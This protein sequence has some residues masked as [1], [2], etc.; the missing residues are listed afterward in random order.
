MAYQ[1]DA[2]KRA[3]RDSFTPDLTPVLDRAL[4]GLSWLWESQKDTAS[5]PL[6]AIRSWLDLLK[7]A[8]LSDAGPRGLERTVGLRATEAAW[9]HMTQEQR[10]VAREAGLA[11]TDGNQ[12]ERDQLPHPHAKTDGRWEPPIEAEPR[13]EPKQDSYPDA[14]IDR[15][16]NTGKIEPTNPPSKVETEYPDAGIDTRRNTGSGNTGFDPGGGTG[17][18]PLEGD[19]S[20]PRQIPGGADVWQVDNTHYLVYRVPGTNTPLVWQVEDTE[21]R[22]QIFGDQMPEVDRKLT[23]AEFKRLSPWQINGLSSELAV[24]LENP[25]QVFLSEFEKAAE[26]RPWLNDPSVTAVYAAAYLE[27]REPSTDELATTDWWN[28]HT[29]DERD[30]MARS[31]TAGDKQVQRI[32]NDA[33]RAVGEALRDAGMDNAHG[34]IIDYIAMRR[35]TGRWSESYT[36]EQIRKLTDPEAEGELDYGLLAALRD[37]AWVTGG[38]AAAIDDGREAVMQRLDDLYTSRNVEPGTD[39]ESRRDALRRLTNAVMAGERTIDDI[40]RSADWWASKSDGGRPGGLDVT[41][42]KEDTVEQLAARWLG[43]TMGQ[44][45]DDQVASWA[46]KLRN[47]PDAELEFVEMLKQQRAALFPGYENVNLTY[48]DIVSP[49]RNLGSQVWGQPI[50]DES[51]LVDLANT[52]DYTEMA[53]RLRKQGLEQGIQKPVQDALTGLLGTSIGQRVQRSTI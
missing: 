18:G 33:K 40:R 48:E 17:G 27:G 24:T 34:N 44:M 41:R 22:K 19:P 11:P 20:R 53:K 29:A 52:Q 32:Y 1:D 9:P 7:D 35:V 43:P 21:R 3:V 26:L 13:E 8:D 51:M 47:D 36:A 45:S 39:G 49:V 14:G 25:W 4:S 46:G 2:L 30:W 10:D 16:R 5:A 12:A 42:E 23:K 15:N 38:D 28:E 31:A 6:R 50:T 37:P